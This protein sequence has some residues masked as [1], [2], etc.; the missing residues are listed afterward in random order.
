MT[1]ALPNTRN[2]RTGRLDHFMPVHDATEV[3]A[4]AAQLRARQPAWAARTAPQR[5]E[6]LL[7]WRERLLGQESA[8]AEAL[9]ADTGRWQEGLLEIQACAASLARWASQGPGLLAPSQQRA[10]I[11]F[12]TIEQG[13]QPY[14]LVGV[15]SPWNFPLLLSLIDAIPALMAGCAVLVKPSEITPRFVEP[16]RASLAGLMSEL[17]IDFVTGA[18]ATGQAL[19]DCV[20]TIAF[21]GSVATGRKVAE[22]AARR[23]IP[24]QLELG[25]KDAALVFADADLPRTARSLAWGS[26]VNAG[27]SCMSLERCYVQQPVFQ[28]FAQLLTERVAALGLNTSDP[29]EGHIGPVIAAAQARLIQAQLDD[30]FAQGARALCGGRLVEHGGGIWCQPTVLVD[31]KP[32]MRVMREETFG[33]ILPLQAFADEAE[34]LHL[35]NDSEYGLSGAVFSADV[36]R[37][38]RVASALRAGAVSINDCSLTALVHEGAKQSFGLSGLGGTRMGAQSIQRFYRQQVFLVSNGHPAPWWF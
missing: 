3:A 27:Q 25:G 31:V 8:L 4:V 34:A 1:E 35:A 15:I 9:L 28:A 23:F 17:P 7:A 5:A 36:E 6:A 24:A 14:P 26:M 37:A 29:R 2:P 18:G 11:P 30:A 33:P 10:S 38:R 21:T 22:Q 13:M 20:D 19:I 16:L 12:L 32:S